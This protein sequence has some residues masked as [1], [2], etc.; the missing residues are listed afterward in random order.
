MRSFTIY[1]TM[2]LSIAS[3]RKQGGNEYIR[4]EIKQKGGFGTR[5][6]CTQGT[7]VNDDRKKVK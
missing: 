1:L 4:K 3:Q 5:G 7:R 2:Y 6:D